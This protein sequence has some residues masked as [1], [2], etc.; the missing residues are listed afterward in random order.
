VIELQQMCTVT[1]RPVIAEDEPFLLDLFAECQDQLALLRN[2]EA[3][4]LSLVQMQYRGRRLTYEAQYPEASDLL[5][6]LDNGTPVGR[7][8]LDRKSDHWRIVDIALLAAHRRL[9]IGT[10]VITGCKKEC[11]ALGIPLRLSVAHGNLA[12][13]LYVRLGFSEIAPSQ[14]D[15]SGQPESAPGANTAY[16]QMEWNVPYSAE[17]SRDC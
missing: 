13:R 2:D 16:L 3:M 10:A 1:L 11:G 12:H 17:N 15:S 14:T 6:C 5:I 7:L 4:W 9:G 8:L